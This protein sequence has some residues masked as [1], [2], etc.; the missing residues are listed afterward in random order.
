MA[1]LVNWPGFEAKIRSRRLGT[2]TPL[3]VRRILGVSKTS[4]VFLLHRYT[5]RELIVRLKKGLY[6][7]RETNLPEP[8]IANKLYEPS[9]VSLEFA[10]SYHGV[11]PETVY[12]ITSVTSKPT[13]RFE[14][15]GKVFTYRRIKKEAFTGYLSEKQRG[16]TFHIAEPEKAWVDLNYLRILKNKTPLSRFNKERIDKKKVLRYAKLF[17]NNKLISVVKTSLR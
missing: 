13:R 9:Y 6:T 11:I 3:D 4:V 15:V 12:E 17:K 7:L 2:F 14:T 8:Y 1:K 16:F 5:K 10:L